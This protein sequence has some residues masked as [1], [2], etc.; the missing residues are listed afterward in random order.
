MRPP[1]PPNSEQWKQKLE[2]EE[3]NL[4]RD[5]RME[6][7]F[8]ERS[9]LRLDS[10][11]S[12]AEQFKSKNTHR[13]EVELEER[14]TARNERP[15]RKAEQVDI[16]IPHE[17]YLE[18]CFRQQIGL[19]LDQPQRTNIYSYRDKMIAN[20]YQRVFTTWQGMYYE[21]TEQQVVWSTFTE[22]T[23]TVGGD[24]RW[25]AEGISL[26]N[27]IRKLPSAPVVRHRFAVLPPRSRCRKLL[28]TD[29]YYVHVISDENRTK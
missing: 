13:M 18:E 22:K 4:P 17:E 12:T 26:Y 24:N 8:Q 23:T 7:E 16:K 9:R 5:N 20:G 11:R 14:Q 27:P 10:S 25:M 28:R 3:K 15:R 1:K 21:M 2:T 6:V 29:R 19:P